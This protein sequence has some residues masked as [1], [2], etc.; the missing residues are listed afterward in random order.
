MLTRSHSWSSPW[1]EK[2]RGIDPTGGKGALVGIW[3]T[4]ES[5][6]KPV[7]VGAGVVVGLKLVE[8]VSVTLRAGDVRAALLAESAEAHAAENAKGNTARNCSIV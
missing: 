6:G 8:P 3:V 7:A 2:S 5:V 4:V 1:G